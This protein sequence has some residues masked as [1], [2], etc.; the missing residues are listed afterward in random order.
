M[1]SANELREN[2]GYQLWV[3]TNA[4]Q[5]SI[6][7]VLQPLGLT[8]VQFSVLAAVAR[9]CHAADVV[10]QAEVCRWGSLDANMASDVVRSLESR[11]LLVR[12][13][14]PTDRR[15]HRLELTDSGQELFATARAAITPVKE[16]F[17]SPLGEDG[18][19][20]AAM[21]EKLVQAADADGR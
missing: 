7:R 21:L 8:H 18:K 12:L 4:W 10:T 16:A 11:G 19:Q 2:P 9:L 6:R 3:V 17:F 13:E 1:T 20:L 15:A 5:R 14:H